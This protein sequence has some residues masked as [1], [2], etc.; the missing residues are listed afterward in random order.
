MMEQSNQDMK[1]AP[2]D[3]ESSLQKWRENILHAIMR[4][5]FGL[6]FL[7]L[8]AG[9]LNAWERGQ[10]IL[11]AVYIGVYGTLVMLVFSKRVLYGFRAGFLSLLTYI[12]AV[13]GLLE[14][15]LSGDGR[16]FLF[17][18]VVLTATLFG[19]KKGLIAIGI[20]GATAV[21]IAYLLV[22][23]H[24]SVPVEVQANSAHGLAWTSGTIVLLL[25]CIAAIVPWSYLVKSFS[26]S[27]RETQIAREEAEQANQAKSVFLAKMSHELRT[28]L[29]AIIGYAELLQE[30]AEEDGHDSYSS[31]LAKI[32][33]SGEL[34]LSLVSDILDVST[35]E[36]GKMELHHETFAIGDLL[37]DALKAIE[38]LTKKNRNH[39]FQVYQTQEET[40]RTDRRRLQQVLINLLQNAA[41]FTTD[42]NITLTVTDEKRA[43]Q[44]WLRFEISDTGPGISEEDKERIFEAFNQAAQSH[45]GQHTGTG[46]G[47]T[48][49]QQLCELLG[50][51]IKL[52]PQKAQQGATFTVHLPQQPTET[53]SA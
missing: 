3:V 7:A 13:V 27:L 51:E 14:A 25:L 48:I 35:I 43:D 16:V 4:V 47:L 6:G 36:I 46:L 33:T 24:L 31:D 53:P 39:C 38:P 45:I 28:P 15:G 5:L 19:L 17:F 11:A 49:C 52:Q 34:L 1:Q 2:Q 9:L 44:T 20:S 18:F 26:H 21:T 42:G 23:G 12:L 40:M 50:G 8:I 22:N 41:K 37:S 10:W 32:R 29:N 30:E